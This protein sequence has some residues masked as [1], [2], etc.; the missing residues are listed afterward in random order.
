MIVGGLFLP[1]TNQELLLLMYLQLYQS[2]KMDIT[3]C[4]LPRIGY[5]VFCKQLDPAKDIVYAVSLQVC[6]SIKRFLICGIL[7]ASVQPYLNRSDYL[8]ALPTVL[9]KR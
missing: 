1:T 5:V 6:C 3:F 7:V 2:T 9:M 4:L 8:S